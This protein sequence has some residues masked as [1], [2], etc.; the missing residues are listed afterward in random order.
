MSD[1]ASSGTVA[2]AAAI[3]ASVASVS[4]W[5][6]L[7]T[8]GPKTVRL[9]QSLQAAGFAAWTP[10]GKVR[11]P[12]LKTRPAVIRDV[13]IMPTF[14]FAQER[15]VVELLHLA[16][17][18]A[19]ERHPL[20]FS[21]LR[22]ANRVPLIRER[23]IQALRAEEEQA[24]AAHTAALDAEARAKQRKE[25]AEAMRTQAARRKA[26]R[27]QPLSLGVGS[28]IEVDG[29]PALAGLTGQIVKAKNNAAMICFGG[30]LVMEIDAWRLLPI[31]VGGG[32]TSAA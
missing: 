26:L 12:A 27:S 11:Y 29:M 20:T 6:V 4:R 32:S 18:R 30:S 31:G 24:I 3:P 13:A 15:H 22:V 19:E 2:G 8:A 10:T 5:C 16:D 1:G 9:A 7:R 21:L 17:R 14:V 25:R 23:D 28:W